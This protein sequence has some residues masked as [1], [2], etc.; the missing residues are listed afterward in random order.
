[1][2]NFAENFTA[3]MEELLQKITKLYFQYGIRSVTMDD[4]AREMGMSK[5]TLYVHFK[6]KD[7]VVDKVLMHHLQNHRCNMA[8]LEMKNKNAIDQL[9]NISKFLIEHVQKVNPT[10][11]YD[12]MKYYPATWQK[13]IAYKNESVNNYIKANILKG[14]EEGLFRDDFNVEIIAKIYAM[15]L[16]MVGNDEWLTKKIYTFDEI[17]NTIFIYHLRGIASKK[18]LTYLEEKIKGNT[19]NK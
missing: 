5:K 16:D 10:V 11:N 19:F 4:L 18:G 7:D 12:L 13:V 8:F 2:I 1:M 3:E 15:R 17:F 14:I 9:L 6:D